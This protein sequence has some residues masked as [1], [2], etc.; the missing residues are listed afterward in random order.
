MCGFIFYLS[1][2]K[3]D[4][5]IK[6]ELKKTTQL[7][8]HR[9]PDYNESFSNDKIFAHHCRLSIQDLKVRS[10]QPF[11]SKD[12]RYMLLFNGEIYNFKILR[13]KLTKKYNFVTSS[14]TEVVLA[15]Y[16]IYGDKFLDKINGMFSI[17]IYDFKLNK[18]LISRDPFGQKPLYYYHD[19]E[20][21]I[22][23]SEIKPIQK[24]KKLK[25]NKNELKNYFIE[26]NFGY[27][28]ETL[29]QN[30][31]QLKA[32]EFGK[33]NKFYTKNPLKLKKYFSDKDLQFFSG[34]KSDIL[35]PLK[36]TIK[37]HLISDAKIGVAISSGLDSRSICAILSLL[38][39]N[40]KIT[41]A[42]FVEFENFNLEKN[43][44]IDFCKNF[45]IKLEIIEIKPI[46]IIKKFESCLKYNESPLGGIMNIGLFK[47]CEKVKKDKLK[48]ILGGY[49]LDEA[50]GGYDILN[51]YNFPNKVAVSS[52]LIDG[53]ILNNN[54][55]ILKKSK[56][57]KINKKKFVLN[58]KS[59]HQKQIDLFFQDKIPRTLHMVDRFSMS[60][61]IEFR[62]PFIDKDFVTKCLQIPK[63]K[64]FSKKLGKMP[65]RNTLK[66]NFKKYE[67]WHNQ[68]K[69][70]Q[71]PQE[72][73]LRDRNIKKWI[74]KII[75]QQSLY[76]DNSFLNEKEI[77][78]YW[79]N[80]KDKKINFS[81]PIWQVINLYFL[82]KIF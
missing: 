39:K 37:K 57:F 4:K 66:S 70:V 2:K 24:L 79:K 67:Y 14:D 75:R 47:L 76:K 45:K 1:K 42:Y 30:I 62:N 36:D 74:N 40:K 6:E 35:R 80:F 9:G 23:S 68:K 29:I 41:K 61:S 26:N 3:I 55:M 16:L 54:K 21:F 34:K 49:G 8:K 33:F 58:D 19:K 13:K 48:V 81:L 17:L 20:A 52:R 56:K 69:S 78:K 43:E 5:N 15:A 22:V 10:K 31:Y 12:K 44:V 32:G 53:T 51:P 46:D 82:N 38:K 50:L 71:S 28:K 72:E 59:I 18:F 27:K 25:I 63:K 77:N 60:N 65:V 64:Y 11:F 7:I 73:W